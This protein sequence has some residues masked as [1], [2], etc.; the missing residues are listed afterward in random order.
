[1]NALGFH[2]AR[3]RST[4][5][6]HGSAFFSPCASSEV[7]A[8]PV[9]RN[10]P[11]TTTSSTISYATSLT[12]S[13]PLGACSSPTVVTAIAPEKTR[14]NSPARASSSGSPACCRNKP[15]VAPIARNRGGRRSAC[16]R[17]GQRTASLAHARCAPLSSSSYWPQAT[18]PRVAFFSFRGADFRAVRSAKTC[19]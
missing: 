12:C 8:L 9:A 3:H 16:A 7:P 1:M 18:E 15:I 11:S 4:T 5:A 17:T 13:L 10:A 2:R 14:T 6:T 19:Q